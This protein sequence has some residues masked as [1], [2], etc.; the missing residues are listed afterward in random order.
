MHKYST[1]DIGIVW[2]LIY[3]NI[4]YKLER[5]GEHNGRPKFQ[6]V[7]EADSDEAMNQIK[8]IASDYHKGAILVE[9]RKFN[10]VVRDTNRRMKTEAGEN[11]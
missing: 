11:V 3:N 4:P 1:V 9:P 8:Q 10:N 6:F 5:I 2:V 7:F